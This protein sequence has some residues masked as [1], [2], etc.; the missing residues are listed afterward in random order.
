MDLLVDIAGAILGIS[1]SPEM[2]IAVLVVVA[3]S[4]SATAFLTALALGAVALVGLKYAMIPGFPMI[5]AVI[6]VVAL[7]LW[8]AIGWWLRTMIMRAFPQDAWTHRR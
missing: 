8:S 1:S 5:L 3:F 4:S 6:T 7:A 2:W